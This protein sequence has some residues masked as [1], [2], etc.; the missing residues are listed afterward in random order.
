MNILLV[1]KIFQV[2]ALIFA[3]SM[4]VIFLYNSYFFLTDPGFDTSSLLFVTGGSVGCTG[5][6]IIHFD[7]TKTIEKLERFK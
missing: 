7:L 5:G 1:I 4:A 6:S 3:L 2:L